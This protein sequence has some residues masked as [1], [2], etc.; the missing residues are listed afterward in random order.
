VGILNAAVWL[1]GGIFFTVALA[2]AIFSRDMEGVLGREYYPYFSGAIA[3]VLIARYFHLQLI[4]A[5]VALIH[6]MA[7]WLYLGKSAQK[8]WLGLVIGLFCLGLVGGFWLQPRLK[9]LH[10]TRYA[11][12]TPREIREAAN[13]S[14]RT[15]HGASQVINLLMLCGLGVY[16]WHLANPPDP[17]RF[18]SAATFRS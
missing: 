17:T 12:N 15:L 1:G 11:V 14:F 8:L 16:F 7:E 2:P 6:F 5:L 9:E 10:T 18:L 13:Q 4:C 3:Q